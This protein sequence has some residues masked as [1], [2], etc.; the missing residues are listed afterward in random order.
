MS[1]LL[2][3]TEY[4]ASQTLNQELNSNINKIENW[5]GTVPKYYAAA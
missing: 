5:L 4:G 1:W 2:T 3:L